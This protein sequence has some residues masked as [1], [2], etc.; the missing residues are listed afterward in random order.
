MKTLTRDDF[1]PLA[2]ATLLNPDHWAL[3]DDVEEVR[4]VADEERT[5]SADA[6]RL[7][8]APAEEPMAEALFSSACRALGLDAFEVPIPGVDDDLPLEEI[9]WTAGLY[10][11]FLESLAPTGVEGLLERI[12]T[13]SGWR[14]RFYE[15]AAALRED[16]PPALPTDR[17]EASAP[18]GEP[19]TLA[20][21]SVALRIHPKTTERYLRSGELKGGRV[22][23]RWRI[24]RASVGE[25]LRTARSTER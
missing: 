12:R 18:E 15:A 14:A 5:A 20:E 21:A 7:L 10:R 24:P 17:S 22:G 19:F 16:L 13:R 25:F 1:W 3:T 11:A 4:L 2:E 8:A 9:T 23:R 6:A